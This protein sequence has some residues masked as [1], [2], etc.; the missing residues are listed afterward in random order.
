VEHA[1]IHPQLQHRRTL[2]VRLSYELLSQKRPRI[3]I[4][5]P[6][7]R[8]PSVEDGAK[9]LSPLRLTRLSKV[10]E[11]EEEAVRSFSGG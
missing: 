4:G 3:H 7:T 5:F 6:Q 9:K 8:G 1:G 2:G 11:S 10:F